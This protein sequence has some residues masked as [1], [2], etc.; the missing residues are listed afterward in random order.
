MFVT[1]CDFRNWQLMP[2]EKPPGLDD[3]TGTRW[4]TFSCDNQ[5]RFSFC[6]GDG[7]LRIYR[8][9]DRWATF[10]QIPLALK[11][12]MSWHSTWIEMGSC[13]A[14]GDEFKVTFSQNDKVVHSMR[15][16]PVDGLTCW[17]GIE[18]PSLQRL[19]S[20]LEHA[21]R[22]YAS[23]GRVDDE[24]RLAPGLCRAPIEPPLR[25]ST[26]RDETTH[27]RKQYYLFARNREAYLHARDVDQPEGQI[28]IKESFYQ[29]TKGPL[30]MMMKSNGEWTYATASPDG[31]TIT[32]QGKLPSCMECHESDRTRD[33]MFGLQSCASAK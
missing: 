15:F 11:S 29:K 9:E 28:V 3:A 18:R 16:S 5:P 1:R 12:G 4:F 6:E 20:P 30:F 24:V 25:T 2:G 7:N 17:N 31:K 33:R 14:E 19:S 23:W 8:F 10:G 22:T 27:G 26:S 13:V 21:A 32:A